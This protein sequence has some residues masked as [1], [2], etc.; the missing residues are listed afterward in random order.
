MSKTRKRKVY[1]RK[2]YNQT[3]RFFRWKRIMIVPPFIQHCYPMKVI[4][5]NEYLTSWKSVYYTIAFE[6]YLC[7]QKDEI[8]KNYEI[9]PQQIIN[10]WETKCY[11]DAYLEA[12]RKAFR[13]YM[14][15]TVK[16]FFW[17]DELF[18]IRRMYGKYRI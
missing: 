14:S 1:E 12:A 2:F 11:N 6:W 4:G 13:Y 16:N 5:E 9:H 10:M 8:S 7:N 17:P 15:N 18:K 3:R